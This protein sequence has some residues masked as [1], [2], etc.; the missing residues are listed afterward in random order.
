MQELWKDHAG[1]SLVQDET[2]M[3]NSYMFTVSAVVGQS[4]VSRAYNMLQTKKA[5]NLIL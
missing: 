5:S 4:K 2:G 3:R 1:S